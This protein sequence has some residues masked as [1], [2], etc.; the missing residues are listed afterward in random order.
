MLS[1]GFTR[2]PVTS[3]TFRLFADGQGHPGEAGPGVARSMDAAADP[4]GVPVRLRLEPPILDLR[5]RQGS[6]RLWSGRFLT[7]GLWGGGAWLMGVPVTLGLALVALP[8]LMRPRGGG[9][10]VLPREGGAVVQEEDLPRQALAEVFGLGESTL[11][12]ARHARSNTIHHNEQGDIVAIDSREPG[13]SLRVLG[14]R[15]RIGRHAH[16]VG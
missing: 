1:S 6:R 9:S 14:P 15:P 3:A 2:G 8:V 11:F 16:P 13:A 12:R 4:V 7:L 10:G 5:D